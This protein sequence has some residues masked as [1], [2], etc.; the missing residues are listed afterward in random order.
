MSTANG[1]RKYYVLKLTLFVA[2][3][4]VVYPWVDG[5]TKIKLVL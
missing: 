5:R 3:V 2:N 1:S 4:G